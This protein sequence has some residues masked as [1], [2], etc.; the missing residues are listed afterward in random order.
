M[1]VKE[2]VST[3][4]NFTVYPNPAQDSF[5]VSVSSKLDPNATISI[6]NILGNK[7]RQVRFTTVPQNV[8]CGDLPSGNYI[9]VIQNG[10]ETFRSTIVKQ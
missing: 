3:S 9:I 6:Y 2:E 5:N 4:P 1:A 7:I 8:F 10:V